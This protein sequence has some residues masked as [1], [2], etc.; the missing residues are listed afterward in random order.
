MGC[1]IY[2]NLKEQTRVFP[3]VD[4]VKNLRSR[5]DATVIMLVGG[6]VDADN[7]SEIKQIWIQQIGWSKTNLFFKPVDTPC[8]VGARQAH[9]RGCFSS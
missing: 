7:R 3:S 4:L 5:D 6:N 8:P 9:P 1:N 2:L